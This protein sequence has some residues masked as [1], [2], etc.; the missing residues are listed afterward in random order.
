M[1]SSSPFHPFSQSKHFSP[2]QSSH[3]VLHLFSFS[4]LLACV[5]PL[6]LFS[7]LL[8][9][10]SPYH[11]IS[12]CLSFFSPP[13]PSLPISLIHSPPSFTPLHHPV[14]Q[15]CRLPPWRPG[16]CRVFFFLFTLTSL[17]PRFFH[18]VSSLFT[19]VH[20][21]SLFFCSRLLLPVYPP[22][23]LHHRKKKTFLLLF[24][25]LPL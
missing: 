24:L 17:L 19:S 16:L 4:S 20:F 25:S 2:C 7:S 12:V 6:P 10:L 5:S 18:G 1:P 21:L 13:P 8:L 15:L 11:C 3:R 9:F 22:P 23:P 14:C